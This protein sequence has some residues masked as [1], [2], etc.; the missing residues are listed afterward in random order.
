MK[1]IHNP[2]RKNGF[3]AE[4]GFADGI[5]WDG[6][7]NNRGVPRARIFDF[8]EIKNIE[9]TKKQKKGQEKP[10]VTRAE[11]ANRMKN[12]IR[13]LLSARDYKW[14]ELLDS[15]AKAY[16][17]KFPGETD[18]MN[19]LKGKMGSVF[20][21]LEAAKETRFES[22]MCSLIRN[23]NSEKEKKVS[24]KEPARPVKTEKNAAEPKEAD[25]KPE[26]KKR[27]RKPKAEKAAV[28]PVSSA[29]VA[30]K[31]ASEQKPEAAAQKETETKPEPKKR[32]RKPKAEKTAPVA[33]AVVAE[34]P[35]PEQKA[36]SVAQKETEIKP[37]PKK[38][39]RKPKA[40]KNASVAPAIVAEKPVPEQKPTAAPVA[41]VAE[42]EEKKE[43]VVVK[44]FVEEKNEA[45]VVE[46]IEEKP[47]IAVNEKTEKEEPK[48]L[49]VKPEAKVVPVFDMTLLFG[50]KGKKASEAEKKTPAPVPAEENRQ[51]TPEVKQPSAQTH[52]KDEKRAEKSEL[53]PAKPIEQRKPV[54]QEFAF[55]GN[56][57]TRNAAERKENTAVT[58]KESA[59]KENT[60][61]ESPRALS[62]AQ[63]QPVRAKDSEA[64]N[65]AK[66]QAN[67][68]P[69]VKAQ[70]A[71]VQIK[72]ASRE[73]N[74]PNPERREPVKEGGQGSAVGNSG[75]AV[76]GGNSNAGR[77]NRRGKGRNVAAET[78]EVGVKAEF[79]KRLRSLGGEYFEYYSVYL[80]ERYSM[81][82]G[83]R[84]EG[85]RI[86]GG[87]HDGGID[88][89]IELTDKF[90]FRETIYIQSKNWD[91]SKGEIEKWV[92]G[93]T[94]LQQ[95]IGAVTCR[96]A[97][98]G[99]R[100]CRG[101]FVTTSRFTSE[102]K[103]LLETM[104]DRFV[105][106]DSDDVFEA[107]KECSFGLIEKNGEWFVDEELLSGDKAFF[108]LL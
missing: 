99:G 32:G 6:R 92:V 38:R 89:E 81:R 58:V 96:I 56:A 21:L 18:D 57:A 66:P 17:D 8:M 2:L 16:M 72:D 43:P 13:E 55:L 35:V 68:Q 34:K 29:V 97:K 59:L 64:L 1:N 83:R 39:G 94:L 36:D 14:N 12:V 51:T 85:L 69:S 76:N 37:E 24:V 20:S 9:N 84:L 98:E 67:V 62:L 90:G 4:P 106:Y 74:K 3:S 53:V 33:S 95:F 101:I 80:L 41:P 103:N 60:E 78:T 75:N 65:K 30:E 71:S 93:E 104:S 22:G 50:N 42:I 102:A 47:E 91:P 52:E 25:A 40:E 54:L 107:A 48:A 44:N 108:N 70:P 27:G 49:T 87:I 88:G 23:E 86:S 79:L 73:T 77:R 45:P 19:D 15:S 28:A 5:Q 63:P 46:T 31:S 61:K 10:V 26:P 82:N 11:K 105:G 100:N 7:G